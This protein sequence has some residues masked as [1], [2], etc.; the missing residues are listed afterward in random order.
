MNILRI[1]KT[2]GICLACAIFAGCTYVS[3]G[4]PDED[5]GALSNAN[6]HF[7]DK[8][9][10]IVYPEQNWDASDSLWFYNT[11]QGSN[12]IDYEI[13]LNLKLANSDK[14]FRSNENLG[15]YR[16]LLQNPTRDNEE[17]LPVGWVKDS[18]KG[19]DYIGFTCAACHTTQVNHKGI[20]I[21]IDGGPAMTDVW[22][23]F[24]DLEQALKASLPNKEFSKLADRILKDESSDTEKRK[25]LYDRLVRDSEKIRD[26]NQ[27]DQP[28]T[29]KGEDSLRY[30]YARLDAF[31]RIFNRASSH[32]DSSH[33]G[34]PANAPVSYPFLWD[35]PQ[36]DFVQWNGIAD[37]GSGAGVGPLGR[38][39]GEVV[40]VFASV[41]VEK[42]EPNFLW[43]LLW[44]EKP[45]YS[46]PSSVRTF[47]QVRLEEHVQKL[48]S[49]SWEQLAK[50][51][52]LPGIDQKLVERGRKVFDFYKCGACHSHIDRDDE[53]RLVVAQFT[54]VDLIETD[55]TMAS[56]A[57]TYCTQNNTLQ[58][59]NFDM[60]PGE[61]K[62]SQGVTGKSAMTGITTGVLAE[63]LFEK[64]VPFLDTI[65][66]NPWRNKETE[67]HVDFE[68]ANKDYLY[69]YKGRPL[70]GIWATAPFLHNGSVPNLYELLLPSSCEKADGT[71]LK[72][73]ETCRSKTFTVGNRELDPKNVGFV[74]ERDPNK[75]DPGLFIFDTSLPGN[76]NKGH[77]YA[78]G[79]TP[80]VRRDVDGKAIRK[81]NGELDLEY[82]KPPIEHNDR[83]ALIEYLK[84]L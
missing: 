30:G 64:I 1:L 19:N 37:N 27:E 9:T 11:S 36:H 35:T 16:Y 13:F 2:L 5:R 7:G 67:R 79:I 73:G 78:A 70:N 32:L 34:R 59:L 46:Y 29:I 50:K 66:G 21:R 25:N 61:L 39:T 52:F 8:T 10:S 81:Q 33:T 63:G 51:G 40:G 77:E 23:M 53:D 43:K 20:G 69:V 82:L 31:G 17:A 65:Y 38:N 47:N 45:T 62:N 42:E 83:M 48:W 57:L 26:Y 28:A 56:N 71:R 18:Y 60:C 76:F 58:N 4:I 55:P 14:L 84:S 72:P 22:T 44:S 12:L 24:V 49:P 54:R 75:M 74:Q 15:K 68:V 41:K 6:D 80:I 3:Q